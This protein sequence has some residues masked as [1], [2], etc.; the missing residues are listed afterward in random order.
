VELAFNAA[1]P[2][3]G[4]YWVVE[5]KLLAG[6][7]PGS[8]DPAQ[9]PPAVAPLLDAGVTTFL[10]LQEAR[11]TNY[12]G[13][14]S[15]R[16]RRPSNRRRRWCAIR[17]LV[18]SIPTRTE[19]V[20]ILDRIDASLEEGAVYVH[21]WGGVGRTGTVVGCWL[22]R[23]GLATPASVIDTIRSL[24]NADPIRGHRRSPETLQQEQ[25]VVGW[26]E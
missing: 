4:T 5:H 10:N 8:P 9:V 19:M 11:E 25:F 18:L 13:S 2:K 16:M 21:C 14:C 12:S 6:P 26:A 15:R 24:G 22:L 1:P 7:F 3:R 23:H 17:L 20:E